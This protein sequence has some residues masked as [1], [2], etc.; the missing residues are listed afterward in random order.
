MSDFD[1]YMERAK[2]DA[3]KLVEDL[4]AALRDVSATS[5]VDVQPIIDDAK[6]AVETFTKQVSDIIDRFRRG[7]E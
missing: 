1:D 6:K 2:R 5:H 7:Q 3:A 4:K